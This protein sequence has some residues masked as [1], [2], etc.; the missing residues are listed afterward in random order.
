M[1]RRRFLQA[2][3]L[4]ALAYALSRGA[5]ASQPAQRPPRRLVCV[6]VTGAWDTAYALDPRDPAHADMRP[7]APAQFEGLDVFV[8]ASR[9]SVTAFFD[10]WAGATALVRGISTDAINHNEC[11][12]RIATGT[13]E[14]T[15]PDLGAIV[16]HDL[17]NDLPLPYLILGDTAWTGPY[18]VSSGRVGTTNQ[19]VEL[20]DPGT[21]PD[22]VLPAPRDG[23]SDGEEQLLREYAGASADR[24]HAVRG[25]QGYNRRRVD[26]FVEAIDRAKRLRVLRAGLGRRGDALAFG[27]Q[28]ELAIDALAQDI[29]HAVMVTTGLPWD[30]HSDNYLQN[31][32]HEQ[33]FAGVGRLVDGLAARPGRA[34]GTTMLDDTVVAVFSEMSR[35]LRIGSTDPHAGTGHWPVTSALVIGAGVRG[36]QTFGAIDLDG[37]SLPIDLATGTADPGGRVLLYSHF[38]AGLLSLCGVDPAPHL[39]DIPVCDAFAV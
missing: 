22:S 35:T 26:D 4:G 7:G 17:G 31:G 9:P 14:E 23:L 27:S 37:G 3:G 24:A 33:L 30:T 25:A 15:R 28:L 19:I 20:L 11:Q 5:R 16:A 32:F 34:A 1:Q 29:S 10:K 6:F 21:S 36:G 38:V 12:R 2:T 13:R 18:A 8:D 39:V